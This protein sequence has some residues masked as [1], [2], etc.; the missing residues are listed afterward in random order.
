LRGRKKDKRRRGRPK[1]KERSRNWGAKF[2]KK[3][4]RQ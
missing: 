4:R 3:E 1:Q 2:L